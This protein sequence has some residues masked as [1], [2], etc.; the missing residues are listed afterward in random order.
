MCGI[1]CIR[2]A[3]EARGDARKVVLVP[4]SGLTPQ[5]LRRFSH[6]LGLQPAVI[7][8]GL[9]AGER[10]VSAG[11]NKLRNGQAVVVD[12]RPAPGERAAQE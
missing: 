1:L 3:L 11:H 12:D 10:V 2:A 7:H 8:S 5:L 6:R 4:E 9:S